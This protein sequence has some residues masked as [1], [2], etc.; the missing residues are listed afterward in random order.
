MAKLPIKARV[1]EWFAVNQKPISA[2]GLSEIL[3][4]EY[5]G[6]KT[7]TPKK[8]EQQILCYCRVGFLEPVGMGEVNGK[9]E[10]EYQITDAGKEELEYIPG[11][12]NKVF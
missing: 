4:K 5:P 8:L 12:G 1:L 3:G 11:H 2:E 6:E 7:V 9:E 10:L